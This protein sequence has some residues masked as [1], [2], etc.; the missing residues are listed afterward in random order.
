[1]K[2]PNFGYHFARWEGD[3]RRKSY[4]A[5][6]PKIVRRTIEPAR[7]I[8]LDVYS[9]SGEAML[10]EQVRSIR[11]FLYH[12]GRPKSFTVISDGSHSPGSIELLKEIDPVVS[13][14]PTGENLP[15]DLPA[16]FRHYVT[17][18]PM[19]KQLGLIM[20]LPRNAPAF[21][22]DSDILFFQGAEDL[23]QDVGHT[24]APAL[25]LPDCQDCSADPRVLREPN[26]AREPVNSGLVLL[27]RP[28]DWSLG[29]RRFLELEGEPNF[30]TNQ[31]LVHLVMHANGAQ[32]LDPK[33]Y[34]LQLDDQFIYSDQYAG[35]QLVLRHYVNPV[36]HK[37]WTTP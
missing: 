1:M 34:V 16:K 36:R 25:Y 11:S 15:P 20:S 29:I 8:P 19:G 13:I 2:I 33:R 10:P 17:T 22:V 4:R 30:F 5:R 23:M 14:Q 28:L 24:A 26:E 18:Y 35:P 37:F 31:T 9:Y 27:L 12:A 7:D 3:L 6:L 21:Y 32:P